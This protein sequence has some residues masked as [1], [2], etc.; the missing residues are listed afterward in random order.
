[1]DPV[2]ARV[3]AAGGKIAM[4]KTSIGPNGFMAFIIDTEGNQVGIHS[5]E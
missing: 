5:T 2:L 4:P 3:E 1:M